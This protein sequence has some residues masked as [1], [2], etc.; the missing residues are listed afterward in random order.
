MFQSMRTALKFPLVMHTFE[1][2]LEII[3]VYIYIYIYI[4]IYH[5]Q[6]KILNFIRNKDFGFFVK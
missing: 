4:Y 3:Y 1:Y 5:S 6:A 2:N